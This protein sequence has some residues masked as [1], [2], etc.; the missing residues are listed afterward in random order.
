MT[1]CCGNTLSTHIDPAEWCSIMDPAA[2][3]VV[4]ADGSC[5]VRAKD[6][7]HCCCR[8]IGL[9]VRRL[10]GYLVRNTAHMLA[11]SR[12]QYD[13]PFQTWTGVALGVCIIIPALLR[14]DENGST[15]P[16]LFFVIVG[17]TLMITWITRWLLQRQRRKREPLVG[18]DRSTS[19]ATDL[20]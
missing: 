7:L 16:N 9:Q 11:P 19:S 20:E 1:S 3:S 14:L 8:S 6:G 18:D 2:E 15:G 17:A 4:A 13:H 12:R 10:P 5:C